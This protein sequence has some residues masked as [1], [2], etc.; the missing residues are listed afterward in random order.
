MSAV[1]MTED[2]WAEVEYLDPLPETHADRVRTLIE[3]YDNADTESIRLGREWYRIAERASIRLAR[4]YGTTQ[5]RA[6]GVLAAYSINNSWKENLEWAEEFLAGR[7]KG[8]A[9]HLSCSRRILAGEKPLAVLG[10]MPKVSE[11]YRAI[12]GN[13]NALAMD[14]WALQAAYMQRVPASVG[15]MRDARAAYTDAAHAVGEDPRDLQAI[16]WI[17]VRGA[18]F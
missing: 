15:R 11:F 8:M 3:W 9:I 14:R 12:T 2:E 10:H 1:Q 17:E 6:A 7:P 18:A 13:G 5:H 4:K 16:V